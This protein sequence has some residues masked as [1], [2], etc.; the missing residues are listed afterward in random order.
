MKLDQAL[1]AHRLLA[2]GA[3]LA[4]VITARAAAQT[5]AP[6]PP[7][8]PATTVPTGEEP[9]LG[10]TLRRPALVALVLARNP[11][12]A[13]A[14][15]A[16]RA[17]LARVPQA[18]GLDDP[19]ASYSLAPLSLGSSDVPLGHE[20][21]LSQRLPAPGVRSLRRGVA[22]SEASAAE[23]RWAAL[24]LDLAAMAARLHDELWL[25]ERRREVAEEHVRLLAALQRVA[26]ARYAGGLAP[27]QAPLQAELEAARVQ[28][29]LAELAAERRRL[30]ARLNVLLHRAPEAALP[31]SALELDLAAGDAPLP[32]EVAAEHPRLLAPAAELEARRG[33]LA[34]ARRALLP[35][36]EVMTSYSTMWE[37]DEHRWMAGVGV[38][39]PV[40]RRRR[41]A[42]VAEAE[43]K[44]AEA[45]AEM[46]ARSDRLRAEV[47]VAGT[48]VEETAELLRLFRDRV[49]PAARDQ[50]GAARTAFESGAGD[51][52]AVI[53]AERALRGAQL[54]YHATQAA[55]ASRRSEQLLALGRFPVVEE[56]MP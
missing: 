9:E 16:W 51:M 18:G 38:G 33:E 7:P 50:L 29:Q 21:R 54:D 32:A 22:A 43:A 27:Q 36:L 2:F 53:E 4:T 3:L 13:A 25:V 1:A 37:M 46:V 47:A 5:P 30:T 45:E 17:A 23:Q 28:Q 42:A 41:H 26:A 52:L 19:M 40:W 48:D 24:R 11:E 15:S 8:T 49:L 35:E 39:L 44:V 14:E 12:G 55:H 20:L 31:P 56:V 34:L 6:P 10:T